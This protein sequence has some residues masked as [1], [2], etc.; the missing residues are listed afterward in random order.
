MLIFK[1]LHKFVCAVEG[2][3]NISTTIGFRVPYSTREVREVGLE[4]TILICER[5]IPFITHFL[6]PGLDSLDHAA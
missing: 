5:P 3:W 2:F 1:V 4:T 6:L